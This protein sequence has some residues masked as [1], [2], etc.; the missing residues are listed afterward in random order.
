MGSCGVPIRYLPQD[1]LQ[2]NKTQSE[3]IE[4]RLRASLAKNKKANC[5]G[6]DFVHADFVIVVTQSILTDVHF[7]FTTL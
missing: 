2:V 4:F 1:T 5:L 7:V 3:Q 6:F